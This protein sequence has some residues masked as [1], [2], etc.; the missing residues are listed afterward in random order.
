M[1]PLASS[2]ADGIR[3]PMSTPSPAASSGPPRSPAAPIGT[4][5]ADTFPGMLKVH[6]GQLIAVAAIGL[7][8]GIVGVVFPGATLLTIAI[9]FG[10][11]LIV[12]GIFRINVAFVA[13]SLS[14]GMRVLT[15]VFGALI[16]VAGILALSNP[17]AELVILAIVIGVGWVL[18][19]IIDIAA[20]VRGVV[21]PRW[22]GL[23]SGVVAIAAGVAMFVLPAAGLVSLLVIGSVL[24]IVVSLTTLLTLPRKRRS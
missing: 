15:G 14:A 21:S 12:S 4:P 11:Y 13:D 6:R 5:S 24:M 23:V 17:F 10:S 22:F 2:A 9:I 20:A 1:S 19:G 7:V 18:E 8:L 16:V 3:I